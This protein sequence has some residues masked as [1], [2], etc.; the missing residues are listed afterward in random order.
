MTAFGDGPNGT[1]WTYG[2]AR[3]AAETRGGRVRTRGGCGAPWTG[4]VTL[5][6]AP[7]NAEDRVLPLGSSLILKLN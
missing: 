4:S 3:L 2:A 7:L 6:A 1:F 5:H